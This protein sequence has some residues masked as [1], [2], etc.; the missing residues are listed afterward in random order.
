MQDELIHHIQKFV[1]LESH[2]ID[3][4]ES[5][6]GLWQIKKKEHVLQEGQICNTMYFV[7]KGSMRQ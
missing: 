6:L 5:C 2:E 3:I 7:V 4:L 1:Q